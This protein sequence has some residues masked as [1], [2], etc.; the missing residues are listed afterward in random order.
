MDTN[1][2]SY[3]FKGDSRGQD[4]FQKHLRGKIWA[5]SFMTIAELDAWA[6]RYG[7]SSSRK[8]RLEALLLKFLI[9]PYDRPLCQMWA[10]VTEAC[11]AQGRPIQPA[12]A[13]IAATAR[14]YQIPLVTHNVKDY[15]AVSGLEILSI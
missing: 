5:A 7:W 14:C 3:L 15:E 12:D 9:L 1:V 8:E 6:I 13:W 4:Y 10:E 2:I 11:R